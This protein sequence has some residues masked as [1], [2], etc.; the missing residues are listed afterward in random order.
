MNHFKEL[1][2]V[3]KISFTIDEMNSNTTKAIIF[4]IEKLLPQSNSKKIM[5]HIG[6]N[7]LLKSDHE[8][9]CYS[10]LIKYFRGIHAPVEMNLALENSF[11]NRQ[12]LMS[13]EY[14]RNLSLKGNFVGEDPTQIVGILNRCR[15]LKKLKVIDIGDGRPKCLM[16][17][18]LLLEELEVRWCPFDIRGCPNLKKLTFSAFETSYLYSALK[19]IQQLSIT[20]LIIDEIGQYFEDEVE[21]DEKP[22]ELIIPSSVQRLSLLYRD[23]GSCNDYLPYV[24]LLP[25]VSESLVIKDLS[26][27]L[28]NIHEVI[29][30]EKL[31]LSCQNYS[32]ICPISV[33]FP[34][35]SKNWK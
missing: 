3:A 6:L 24:L 4:A 18:L 29:W 28:S 16:L 15:S 33:V 19:Y 1:T 14:V 10:K 31:H 21:A 32:Y 23:A 12:L 11:Y 13:S 30:L 34:P 25:P 20:E 8:A 17:K 27:M 9:R 26:V 5:V 2:N 7:N 35:L 22:L